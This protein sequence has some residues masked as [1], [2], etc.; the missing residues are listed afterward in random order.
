MICVNATSLEYSL[1]FPRS[2]MQVN[3]SKNVVS[4]L[5]ICLESIQGV[6]ALNPNN[7]YI[8]L[9]SLFPNLRSLWPKILAQLENSNHKIFYKVFKN[10]FFFH[11]FLLQENQ[12][13]F[14][15][16]VNTSNDL[17]KKNNSSSF[18]W[19]TT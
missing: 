6:H 8:S 19:Q 18:N 13:T 9:Y 2:I 15:T 16:H 3:R 14:N 17:R 12:H 5:W 10:F 7:G 11:F 4:K 1:V